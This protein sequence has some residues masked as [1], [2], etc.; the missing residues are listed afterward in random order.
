[1]SQGLLETFATHELRYQARKHISNEIRDH[2]P[3]GDPMVTGVTVM[4]G[5]ILAMAVFGAMLSGK[6]RSR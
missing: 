6:G 4:I 5:T 2:C 1:M 3:E